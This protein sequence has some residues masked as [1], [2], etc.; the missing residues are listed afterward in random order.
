MTRHPPRS[1]RTDTR[2]PHQT[3]V[4]SA[5]EF[6]EGLPLC[7]IPCPYA[8]LEARIGALVPRRHVRVLLID[9]GD[10][11]A[12][13]AAAVLREL[14]YRDV[15]T[16]AGGTPGWAAAGFTL[17]KGVNVPSKTLSELA[18]HVWHPQTIEAPTLH[19][20]PDGGTPFRLSRQ[21]ELSA[22]QECVD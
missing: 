11:I 2:F 14:G 10:G 15:S 22:G 17:F 8:T 6:G 13:R 7:A 3:L 4:R 16:V 9:G 5:G 18:E 12:A 1:T 19:R 20:W 21:A